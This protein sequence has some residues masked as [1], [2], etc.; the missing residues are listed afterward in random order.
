MVG[1]MWVGHGMNIPHL[2]FL[3][4]LCVARP[5]VRELR[6]EGHV[7]RE[8]GALSPEVLNCDI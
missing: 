4:L 6:H 8:V 2:H 7:A 1:G 3:L 5:E